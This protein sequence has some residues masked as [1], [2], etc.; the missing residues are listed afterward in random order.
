[1]NYE[2]KT[3]KERRFSFIILPSSFIVFSFPLPRQGILFL[4]VAVLAGGDEVAFGGFPST[5]QGDQVIHGEFGRREFL[6]AVMTQPRGA[7]TLPPCGRAEFPRFGLLALDVGIADLGKKWL[8]E[9]IALV[10]YLFFAE[11]R[12]KA[13][14]SPMLTKFST[15][16]VFSHARA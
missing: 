2:L 6:L 10:I 4:V 8:H 16:L 7:L 9:I 13:K 15:H 3:K 12:N 14:A 1:M 11:C 5:H